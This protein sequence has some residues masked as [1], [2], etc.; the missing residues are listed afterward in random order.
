M[1]SLSVFGIFILTALIFTVRD[2]ETN[3]DMATLVNQFLSCRK[4]ENN[5]GIQRCNKCFDQV[6]AGSMR[7][8]GTCNDNFAKFQGSCQ[9]TEAL[10]GINN[11]L[12]YSLKSYHEAIL[13]MYQCRDEAEHCKCKEH[14]TDML[15]GSLSS[16]NEAIAKSYKCKIYPVNENEPYCTQL[17]RMEPNAQ[18]GL[19]TFKTNRKKEVKAHC[20]MNENIHQCNE[21][22]IWT[23][24]TH[25]ETECPKG[26]S[27]YEN[28]IKGCGRPRNTS[29]GSCSSVQYKAHNM[30]YSHVCGI[31]NGYQYGSP[32]AL[33]GFNRSLSI[34]DPYV[35][36]ISITHGT[37]PRQ[38]I[39][40]YMAAYSERQRVCPCFGTNRTVPNF[41]GDYYS[42]ESGNSNLV[43]DINMLYTEDTLWD[44]CLCRYDEV[45]CCKKGSFNVA[46]PKTTSDDIE[47]RVCADEGTD[48]EDVPFTSV[49]IFIS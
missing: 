17:K 29:T 3:D 18:S 8:L 43:A 15:I 7:L 30:T 42:C 39:W 23:S 26:F 36:G 31:V 20:L 49:G 33:S 4:E 16:C 5:G 32:D 37:S 27:I 9:N 38:H 21:S 19:Y 25:F 2:G 12:L 11:A 34:D 44:A 13:S 47:L 46:L 24:V 35:D 40:T 45:P 10:L 41:I 48:N 6:V 1:T 28:A 14:L 22:R